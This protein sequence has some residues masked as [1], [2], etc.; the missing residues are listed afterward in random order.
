TTLD[1]INVANNSPT[2][3]LPVTAA[4]DYLP[5]GFETL[6][7]SEEFDGTSL[8]RSKWCTR[9][10]YG[11]GPA[12]QIPDAV[13]TQWIGQGTL[14]YAN[15]EENQRFRDINK[16]G[17][18]LHV[19]SDGTIKLRA[20]QTD[21]SRQYQN[22][23]AAALRSK[24]KFPADPAVKY[25][26][27][28]R[29]K[30][31]NVRGSWPAFYLNPDLDPTG[32][33]TTPPEIDILEG[34][35]NEVEDTK[36]HITQ[37]GQVNGAQTVTGEPDFT[38]TASNFNPVYGTWRSPVTLRSRWIQAGVEWDQKGVCYYINGFRTACENYKWVTQAGV[39]GNPAAIIAY[40]AVGGAS[41][42]GRH[43]IDEA[44]FPIS[45]EID[46]IRVYSQ[47]YVAD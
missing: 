43:G 40:L 28:A 39:A 46:Y 7:F 37:H 32:V 22:F 15:E 19:V 10:P 31:P 18:D 13:C 30:M 8:D 17:E 35:L 27:T 25:Y 29:V 1:D 2:P 41:W 6:L 24:M 34:A 23:E 3:D 33:G 44:S 36:Y 9:L 20:T 42:A 11:G 45:Y 21:L 12:L 38:F 47:P 16:L 14:D 26:F 4:G 5:A